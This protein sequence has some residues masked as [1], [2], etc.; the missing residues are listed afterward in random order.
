MRTGPRHM[1]QWQCCISLGSRKVLFAI[2]LGNPIHPDP[3]QIST[4][5][6]W[7]ALGNSDEKPLNSVLK[8]QL[9]QRQEP[10]I[11]GSGAEFKTILQVA[12]LKGT[13]RNQEFTYIYI[14]LHHFD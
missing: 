10:R 2:A 8:R 7:I 9:P 3:M 12:A 1:E 13:H 14:Y 5:S 11:G 4:Q 6:A